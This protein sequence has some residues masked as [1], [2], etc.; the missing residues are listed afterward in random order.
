MED[1]VHCSQFA[2]RSLSGHPGEWFLIW[3]SVF[4]SA[5][6]ISGCSVLAVARSLGELQSMLLSP[7]I[8]PISATMTTLFMG[9]INQWQKWL[10]KEADCPQNESSSLLD[11]WAFQQRLPFDEHLYGTQV[12]SHSL[13]IWRDL[14]NTSSPDVF[15][16]NF[17]IMLFRSPWPCSQSIGYSP[18]VSH[19]SFRESHCWFSRQWRMKD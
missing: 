9:P 3:S 7:C 18:W 16:T 14:S 17:P 10:E 2:T 19:F 12:S 8:T 4:V 6:S 11:Y 13:P 5:T 15:L 1:M